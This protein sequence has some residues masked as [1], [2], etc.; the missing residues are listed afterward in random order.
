VRRIDCYE[1]Q[2]DEL[3][4]ILPTLEALQISAFNASPGTAWHDLM[5]VIDLRVWLNE[6]RAA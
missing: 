2:H 3:I 5:P 4:T 6:R 1:K